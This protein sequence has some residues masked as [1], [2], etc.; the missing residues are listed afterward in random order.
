MDVSGSAVRWA[1]LIYTVPASPSRKRAMVWREVKRLGALYL[2]DG[3]CALPDTAAARAGLESLTALV[4]R[5]DGKATLVCDA[6][7]RGAAT[8]A[9]YTEWMRARQGEYAEVAEAAQAL[10]RHIEEETRHHRFDRA[11]L[12]SLTSDLGRLERWLSQVVT[13][14]YLRVGDPQPIVALLSACR[15]ALDSQPVRSN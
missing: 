10:L 3:V 7:L 8:E 1:L 6:R 4:E 5:L 15:A 9:V 13:R 2:R 12:V 14:D 11:E